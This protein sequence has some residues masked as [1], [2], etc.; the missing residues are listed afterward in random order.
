MNPV[1]GLLMIM[2]AMVV[3]SSADSTSTVQSVVNQQS[4]SQNQ[5]F[6]AGD[7]LKITTYPDTNTFPSGMYSIDGKG[8]ADL[9]ILGF[10]KVIDFTATQLE[11]TLKKAFV[12]Q[13]RYPHLKVR[14]LLKVTLLGGFQRPGLYWID[15]HASLWQTIQLGGVPTRSDGLKK[16]K[17]ERSRTIVSADLVPQF[18]SG[19]SL[20]QMGLR[21]G[22]Q[23]V[24]LARPERTSW[25]AF[26]SEVLPLIT[27]TLSTILTGA[28]VYQ[29]YYLVQDIRHNR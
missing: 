5:P 28:T 26:R 3:S 11:D 18:Q 14:P 19:Q 20:Y 15:P 23:L 29:T 6:I 12:E 22:D 13:L 27:F 7:A 4:I 8:Y 10:V 9:P 2:F 17:W 1:R 25:E 21:S 24:A 16:L